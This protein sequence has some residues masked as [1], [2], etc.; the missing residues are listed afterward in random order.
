MPTIHTLFGT[1][2]DKQLKELKGAINEMND[3][4]SKMQNEK[5]LLSSIVD[6]THQR[7]GLPKKII[8]RLAR[9]QYKKNFESETA[10]YKEFEALFE[11][12]NEVK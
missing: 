7:L 3:C 6:T 1:F 10:E 8:N 9:T 5:E 4:M 11:G 2:D 12:I